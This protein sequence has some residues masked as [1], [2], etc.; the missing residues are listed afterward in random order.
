MN[1]KTMRPI[2]VLLV[3]MS[4]TAGCGVKDKVDEYMESQ[5]G[6]LRKRVTLVPF[7]SQLPGL[8]DPAAKIGRAVEADLR[9]HGGIVVVDYVQVEAAMDKVNSAVKDPRERFVLACRS[10][11]VSGVV[12]GV[13][14]DMS[15][16]RD[17]TG[18]YGFRE[19]TP[20]LTMELDLQLID[21]STGSVMADKALQSRLELS[22]IEANNLR[23]GEKAPANMEA[24]LLSEMS[25]PASKW[26]SARVSAMPWSGY[27]LAVDGQRLQITVG[28]D[29]G[30]SE[31]DK[32]MVYTK[33][34]RVVT[35]SGNVVRL[36]GRPAGLV[37]LVQFDAR[38]AWAV[39]APVDEDERK[40]GPFEPGQVVLTK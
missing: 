34:E 4:L 25:E 33:G 14:T 5:D 20:F 18:I 12:N 26:A 9:A 30:L 28:R 36:L 29:T 11:G 39:P 21:V 15:V 2:L 17:K 40:P 38:T 35:G 24:Q 10:L 6:G 22:D 23:M 3:V 19:N 16:Q 7:S 32:L 1:I 8:A 27:V 13:L 31:G 37:E